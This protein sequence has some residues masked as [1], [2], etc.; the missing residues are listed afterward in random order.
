MADLKRYLFALVT[1]WGY[2]IKI[3]LNEYCFAQIVYIHI[4]FRGDSLFRAVDFETETSL[5]CGKKDL[6]SP[7][8]IL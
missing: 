2:T 7:V 4:F 3:P 8:G 1:Y 5:E 6:T